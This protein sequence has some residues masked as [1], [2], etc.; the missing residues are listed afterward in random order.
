MSMVEPINKSYVVP[1][2]NPGCKDCIHLTGQEEVFVDEYY[3]K[4]PV[5]AFHCKHPDNVI[6]NPRNVYNWFGFLKKENG[7]YKRRPYE[8]NANNNC[9]WWKKRG[10]RPCNF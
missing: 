9:K 5:Y 6:K 1:D 10:G 4:D 8:I 3:G 7:I 2:W